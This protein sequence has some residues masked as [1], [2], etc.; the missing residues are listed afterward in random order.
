MIGGRTMSFPCPFPQRINLILIKDPTLQPIWKKIQ[1]GDR[2]STQDGLDM[3]H[4]DDLLGL[5][6]MAN[7]V[8]EKK[9]GSFAT[10]VVNRQINPTNICVLSCRFCDFATK[11]N[12]PTRYRERHQKK[13]KATPANTNV[14]SKVAW[15]T[16]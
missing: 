16:I 2:L 4:S 6:M 10:F 12:K 7:W 9:T 1:F 8:K 3:F 15:V 5:G 13:K 11:K 14:A